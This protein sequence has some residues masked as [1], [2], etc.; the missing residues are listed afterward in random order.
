MAAR[1]VP[2]FRC[3][4]ESS[5]D[6][7]KRPVFEVSP[8]PTKSVFQWGKPRIHSYLSQQ[9]PCSQ[10]ETLAGL[11]GQGWELRPASGASSPM[12]HA[13][14]ALLNG[15]PGSCLLLWAPSWVQR[16]GCHQQG[17]SSLIGATGTHLLPPAQ[18]LCVQKWFLC[19]NT[20]Q[21]ACFGPRL[22][23]HNFFIGGK[24]S[25]ALLFF[26]SPFSHGSRK[27]RAL[28]AN[29]KGCFV[30]WGQGGERQEEGL[31]QTIKET[32]HTKQAEADGRAGGRAWEWVERNHLHLF[33][34][35]SNFSS[36]SDLG[37][38]VSRFSGRADSTRRIVL[39]QFYTMMMFL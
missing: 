34:G 10:R 1:Q 33:T 15:R 30:V 18:R 5:R 16:P 21:G 11:V 25:S 20:W 23:F 24:R 4:S 8:R 19:R 17:R 27:Q 2:K 37:R 39:G 13:G 9:L 3:L 26:C 35:S 29:R 12:L 38:Q 28:C 36:K 7:K 32:H 6:L 31:S 22:L 14:W